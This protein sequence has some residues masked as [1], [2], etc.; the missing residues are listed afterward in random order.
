MRFFKNKAKYLYRDLELQQFYEIDL[1]SRW[2]II[3]AHLMVQLL[4]VFVITVLYVQ[5]SHV[6]FIWIGL[7]FSVLFYV[8]IMIETTSYLFPKSRELY[9]KVFPWM[10]VPIFLVAAYGGYVVGAEVMPLLTGE[11]H[12]I[13]IYLKYISGGITLVVGL[14]VWTQIGLSQILQASRSLFTKK[15]EVDADIR[16][17]TEVQNR[18]LSDVEVV[19]KNGSGF[20]SSQQANELG[21]DYFELSVR[22][23]FIVASVG[24]VSGH[25]FGAGLLMTMTKSALQTHLE[26]G[27]KPDKIMASLNKL[28]LRQSD[29]AMYA[30]MTMLT[31][32]V[33]TG[34]ALVCNAGHLPVL[35]WRAR[36]KSL[37]HRYMKGLGLGIYEKATFSNLE[38]TVETGDIILLYSD[39]LIETRDEQKQIREMDF[40]ENLAANVIQQTMNKLDKSAQLEDDVQSTS[41][42]K[43]IATN[44]MDAIRKNDHAVQ[45]EDDATLV[46][47]AV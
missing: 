13:F 36:S 33:T 25:S 21:G 12:N 15:A 14:F 23:N 24:D 19:F 45:F 46:V 35:H 6:R 4:P 26:Y 47:L 39:G 30:T 34:K 31:M 5:Y 37:H 2:K 8:G 42:A 44:L 16:F 1:R 17:A 9:K 10:L 43:R 20:A 28:F 32:D 38:F 3:T 41:V 29:R 40:F 22:D 11:G 27:L 7:V 18:F